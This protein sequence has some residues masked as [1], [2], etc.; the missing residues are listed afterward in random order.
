MAGIFTTTTRNALRRLTGASLVSDIDEG[1]GALADDVDS[2]MVSWW[3]D[4]LAKRPAA[5]QPNR[6]FKASDTGVIYHDTGSAW[7]P[8]M[9]A[10]PAVTHSAAFTAQ[11]GELVEAA[12]GPYTITLPAPAVGAVVGVFCN[13]ASP[14]T[15]AGAGGAKIY[16]D[17]VN[18]ASSIVLTTYQHVTLQGNGSAWFIVAGE[19]KKESVSGA[20][21]A[22]AVNTEYE[23]SA[24]RPTEVIVS[25]S[26]LNPAK[27]TSLFVGGVQRAK[28]T[29]AVE[30][31]YT[32]TCLPGE[33]WQMKASSG[34]AT[35]ESSY[36]TL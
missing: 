11:P 20:L 23:P 10:L 8:L 36:R 12:S 29:A 27:P 26:G 16:G 6:F 13:S 18:A 17:F 34:S 14:I 28:E 3:E 4:T 9:P 5:G 30:G 2:K 19:P 21:T 24:T 32:F 1:I 33:K 7:E 35:Y 25:W 22:R 31:S 15:V